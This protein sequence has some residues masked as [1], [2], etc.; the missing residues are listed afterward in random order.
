[1][2][3]KECRRVEND[4]AAELQRGRKGREAMRKRNG[5]VVAIDQNDAL[6][7][8]YLPADLTEKFA[9][10]GRRRQHWIWTLIVSTLLV[11]MGLVIWLANRI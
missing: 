4:A 7:P 9:V 1:V 5:S 2:R 8:H 6:A 3:S 10:A 11:T